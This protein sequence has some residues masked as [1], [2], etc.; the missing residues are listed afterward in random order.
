M[1]LVKRSQIL[2]LDKKKH[3]IHH[4]VT[5]ELAVG[6]FCSEGEEKSF[7]AYT[8]SRIQRH[9][10][11]WAFFLIS[12]TK[13]KVDIFETTVYHHLSCS[14]L[15]PQSPQSL[16]LQPAQ[17]ITAILLFVQ[18]SPP[19]ISTTHQACRE[20]SVHSHSSLTTACVNPSFISC[21]MPWQTPQDTLPP[22]PYWQ[23]PTE[24]WCIAW[25]NKAL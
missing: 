9:W 18:V 17:H 10:W 5:T 14:L 20:L 13:R 7:A 16:S 6:T 12:M 1:Q 4:H 23:C 8:L 21:F 22:A 3:H 25:F 2:S 15:V 19:F 24:N 11:V